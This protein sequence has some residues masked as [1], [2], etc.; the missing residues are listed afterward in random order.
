MSHELKVM[1]RPS[2]VYASLA[3]QP[4][5]T[6]RAIAI[7]RPA[8]VALVIG[9]ATAVSATERI[10]FSLVASGT[11]CWSFVPA[12]Q[13]A[14]AAYVLRSPGRRDISMGRRLDL[15]FM[16]H[17]PW[18]LWLLSACAL[19]VWPPDVGYL[20]LWIIAGGTVPAVW[21]MTIASAFCRTVL[22]DSRQ[23]ARRRT[24]LHQAITWTIVISYVVLAAQVW[25]RF[26]AAIG[27]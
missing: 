19:F 27:R 23:Q 16:G 24:A 25:P 13:M 15:W 12:L 18:S 21:T 20:Q 3:A 14:T 2:A 4:A 22:G 6:G 11:M 10:T 26:L 9:T 8:L 7:R 17:G 1:F 5:S